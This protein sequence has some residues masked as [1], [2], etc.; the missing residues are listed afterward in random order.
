MTR[1]SA[2]ALAAA[3][4]RLQVDVSVIRAVAAVEAAGSGFLGDGRPKILFEAH[5]FGRLTGGRYHTS[6]PTL[7][8]KAWNRKLY[9]GGMGEWERY[10]AAHALDADAAMKATSWGA[11]QI[12]GL[13]H[14]ACA[15]ES[16][17]AMVGAMM[18][19]EDAH[20]MAF[21]GF[22]AHHSEMWKALRGRDWAAFAQRYNG[23]GYAANA[24]D[25][26][27]AAAFAA[28]LARAQAPD[29]APAQADARAV[30]AG[31]NARGAALTPDG[32]V[33][34][35]SRA[36]V[37]AEQDAAAA[38]DVTGQLDPATRA[39]LGLPPQPP[40]LRGVDQLAAVATPVAGIA[41]AIGGLDWRVLAVLAAAGLIGGGLYLWHRSR[42][43]RENYA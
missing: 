35:K 36:V 11:F 19:S 15:F 29:T 41:G 6:H 31:L 42:Q 5:I 40:L 8:S 2:A 24:Y 33:G 23:A 32:F 22:V 21:V 10:L 18:Q 28:E 17:G 27:L 13:N 12:L 34:P 14:A 43:R 4:A 16:V 38:A 20:L 1:F 3:A 9:R 37:A 30:Q 25:T 39:T 7:S 26:K